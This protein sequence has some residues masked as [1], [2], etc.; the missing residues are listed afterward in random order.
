[1]VDIC[2]LYIVITFFKN[3]HLKHITNFKEQQLARKLTSNIPSCVIMI[4]MYQNVLP[5]RV[6][7][8]INILRNSE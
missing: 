7:V 2:S 6:L 5:Q 3:Y 4:S 8:T 1:M